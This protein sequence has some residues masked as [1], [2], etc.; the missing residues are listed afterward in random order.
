M[1]SDPED[2]LLDVAEG[3]ADDRPIDWNEVVRE[4]PDLASTVD[5][6]RQLQAISSA[7]RNPE[8]SGPGRPAS[9]T[10]SRTPLFTWGDIEVLEKLGE[11]GFA[12]VYRAWDPSLEREVALKLSRKRPDEG[13]ARVERWL[14]EA[15][16][17]ARVR[18]A[19]VLVV[20]G[21]D[22]RDGRAGFWT[23]LIHGRTLEKVLGDQGRLGGAEAALIGLDLCRALAAVHAAKLVHGDLKASNVMREGDGVRGGTTDAGRIVLMDFGS[24]DES[25]PTGARSAT[26]VTP[27]TCAPEV[28]RGEPASP[29]SDLYSLGALL[30]RLVTGRY[31]IESN[32][33]AE[34]ETKIQYGVRS[35]LRDLRPDLEATFVAVVEKA[36][37]PDPAH[38]FGS[39]G[40]MEN[41]LSTALSLEGPS[42]RGGPDGAPSGSKIASPRGP[43]RSPLLFWGGAILIVGAAIVAWMGMRRDRPSASIHFT[44]QA[45]PNMVLL[46]DP[47]QFAISPD[48]RQLVFIARDSEGQNRMWVR[49]LGA[50]RPRELVGARG[51]GHPFWSPDGG[52]IGFF[53]EQRMKWIDVDGSDV[54]VICDS[55]NSHGATWG[56]RGV[57]VFSSGSA[58][59]KVPA[60]GGTPTAVTAL[61][62]TGGGA[63]HAWPCFLPDGEHFIYV[64]RNSESLSVDIT[65]KNRLYASYVG[66][67]RSMRAEPLMLAGSVPTYAPPRHLVFVRGDQLFAQQFDPRRRRLMGRPIPVPNSPAPV[68]FMG[69]RCAS[70]SSNGVLAWASYGSPKCRLVWVDRDGRRDGAIGIR[71]DRWICASISPD[72]RRALLQ[73]DLANG[74]RELWVLDLQTEAL[75]RVTSGPGAN[76]PGVW[77]PD[78]KEI[79]YAS[80]VEKGVYDLHRTEVDRVETDRVI[81][82]SSGRTQNAFGWS[83]D[84]KWV[85]VQEVRKGNGF[86]LLLMPA[87][88]G[89]STAYLATSFNERRG[90][91]SP[92]GRWVVYLTNRSGNAQAY[93]ESFPEPGRRRQVS[94]LPLVYTSWAREGRE[95]LLFCQDFHVRSVLL[96]DGEEPRLSA[97]RDLFGLPTDTRWLAPTPDGQRFLMLEPDERTTSEASIALNVNW[98]AGVS[99]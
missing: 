79:V 37:D 15:R 49:P 92:D 86:D 55:P 2:R 46:A 10:A 84:G 13:S 42:A 19:N 56:S 81:Y 90:D 89:T 45:P 32:D 27:L 85:L 59:F 24:S 62:S 91:I 96:E 8:P 97:P 75:N 34:L 63:E 44:V 14:A 21:V 98:R 77:S 87:A 9:P 78:S 69:S 30:Y 83:P 36:L 18:H 1:S 70:V 50:N 7:F 38:R 93:L 95:I 80:R 25:S 51:G 5:R 11:G 23:D 67:L 16:R 94:K 40:Q 73:K 17:L 66:S 35:P 20:H 54:G 31:P 3:L 60:K 22:V 29:A 43:W 82:R 61:D 6:L 99:R 26:S 71:P 72:S 88:G 48:G 52:K 41:A 68:S 76:E 57:I 74:K 58:L 12:E 39:A 4:R 33:I 28:L 47:N 64:T 53:H 65:P